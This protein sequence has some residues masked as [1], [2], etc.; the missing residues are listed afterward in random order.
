MQVPDHRVAAYGVLPVEDLGG[1]DILLE[2]RAS[3]SVPG[4]ASEVKVKWSKKGRYRLHQKWSK[5]GRY[6]LR[7][8]GEEGTGEVRCEDGGTWYTS[9]KE[10]EDDPRRAG[11]WDAPQEVSQDVDSS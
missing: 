7:T 9:T 1:D 10:G 4:A 6:R 2:V 5:K 11:G 3:R 8:A